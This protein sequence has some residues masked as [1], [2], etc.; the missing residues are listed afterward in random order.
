YAEKVP[1]YR[2]L[3]EPSDAGYAS[4]S[5]YSLELTQALRAFDLQDEGVETIYLAIVDDAFLY[6]HPDLAENV[7]IEKCYDVADN[8][9]DTRPPFSGNNKAG[10]L[11]FSHGTHVGGIAGAVTDNGIGIASISN[12]SVKIFG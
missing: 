5:Q 2:T 7:A 3:Y 4:G 9:V 11:T 10:P 8:D 6:D 12:N 1:I